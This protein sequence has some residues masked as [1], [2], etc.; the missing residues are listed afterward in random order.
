MVPPSLSLSA[1]C[2]LQNHGEAVHVTETNICLCTNYISQIRDNAMELFSL[3]LNEFKCFAVL[4]GLVLVL[5]QL[6]KMI[7]Y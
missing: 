7:S 5:Q 6:F 3:K 1:A 4:T 2:F